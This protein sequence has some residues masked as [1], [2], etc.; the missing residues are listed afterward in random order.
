MTEAEA[1]G[2]FHPNCRHAFSLFMLENVIERFNTSD[3]LIIPDEKLTDYSLNMTSKKGRD[4]AIAFEESLG[5]NLTN[6][7]DLIAAVREAIPLYETIPNGQNQYGDLYQT[8]V[9]VKGVNGKTANV[10]LAWIFKRS[11]NIIRL[12]SIYVT[13]K[14]AKK[15][16][17]P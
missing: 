5:Y 14:E 2:L 15:R 8:V 9:K 12:T 17:N 3:E 16:E 6:Y 1:D 7:K 11:E 13:H 10:L 4:K